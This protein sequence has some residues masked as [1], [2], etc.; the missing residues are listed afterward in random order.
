MKDGRISV[1]VIAVFGCVLLVCQCAHALTDD[2]SSDPLAPGSQWVVTG[3]NESA[4]AD[5]TAVPAFQWSSGTLTVN[6]NSTKPTS[7]LSIPLGETVTDA[8]IFTLKAVI[9]IRSENYG[10]DPLGYMGILNFA[11]V[12]TLEL[13]ITDALSIS[14]PMLLASFFITFAN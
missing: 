12:N 4:L 8:N 7:R 9:T 1:S 5:G 2:F 10:A 11:L 13:S 14:R 6:Y 3:T